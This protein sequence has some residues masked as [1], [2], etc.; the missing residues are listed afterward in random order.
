MRIGTVLV[1]K[2]GP[3]QRRIRLLCRSLK[4][5]NLRSKFKLYILIEQKFTFQ[6]S[7]F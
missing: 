3:S 5:K 6:W 2:L 7:L 4:K 1:S